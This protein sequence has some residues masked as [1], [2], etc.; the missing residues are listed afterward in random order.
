MGDHGCLRVSSVSTHTFH[1]H[2]VPVSN[3]D[4]LSLRSLS[5]LR[6]TGAPLPLRK[7]SSSRKSDPDPSTAPSPFVLESFLLPLHV[8]PDLLS[9]S[10]THFWSR[11]TPSWSPQDSF[12]EGTDNRNVNTKVGPQRRTTVPG[13][14]S[15]HE[16]SS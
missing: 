14:S 15:S 9:L 6:K 13:F 1:S 7:T 11:T 2:L 12:D 3:P 5:C 16:V 4:S 10:T 8:N